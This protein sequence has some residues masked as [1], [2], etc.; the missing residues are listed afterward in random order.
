MGNKLLIP[1]S[2]LAISLGHHHVHGVRF[3]DNADMIEGDTDTMLNEHNQLKYNL[4]QSVNGLKQDPSMLRE[5][6]PIVRSQFEKLRQQ[7]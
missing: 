2:V 3:I 7:T 4:V 6:L 5:R 1:T